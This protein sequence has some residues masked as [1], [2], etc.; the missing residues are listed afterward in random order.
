MGALAKFLFDTG[1]GRGVLIALGVAIAFGW[2]SNAIEERVETRIRQEIA[3]EEAASLRE[4]SQ[5]AHAVDH[6]TTQQETTDRLFADELDQ[7]KK[8]LDHER[9]F[10]P[11]D[12]G[13]M[14][15]DPAAADR[16]RRLREKAGN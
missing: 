9:E 13:P 1:V 6:A 15:L 10:N 14:C 7:F 2:L 4:I 12:A 16:L 11:P 3:E 8:E 5:D